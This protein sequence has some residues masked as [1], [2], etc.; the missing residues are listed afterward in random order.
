MN[1]QW[2]I[3]PNSLN[4]WKNFYQIIWLLSLSLFF[5][6]LCFSY[7]YAGNLMLNTTSGNVG[8]GTSAPA[9]VLEVR[10][11]AANDSNLIKVGDNNNI[12]R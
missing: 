6:V 11:A 12:C 7:V 5:S 2:A 1:K 9:S 8:V 3:V 4:L 10:T